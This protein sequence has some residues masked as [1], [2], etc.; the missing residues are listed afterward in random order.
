MND[1]ELLTTILSVKGKLKRQDELCQDLT[2]FNTVYER[3]MNLHRDGKHDD[4]MRKALADL[5]NDIL[6]SKLTELIDLADELKQIEHK[7]TPLGLA[8]KTTK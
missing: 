3:V 5:N 8:I 4:E 2:H 6:V 7:L 1:E